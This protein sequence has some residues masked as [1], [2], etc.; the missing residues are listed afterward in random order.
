LPTKNQ[1]L[2]IV[3][4]VEY[5]HIDGIDVVVEVLPKKL[6]LK[7]VV[8]AWLRTAALTAV[9]PSPVALHLI[10]VTGKEGDEAIASQRF[11][12]A[13]SKRE[14][15]QALEEAARFYV[16]NLQAPIPFALGEKTSNFADPKLTDKE[17]KYSQSYDATY[18]KDQ[19]WDL[20]LGHLDAEDVNRDQSEYGFKKV[21]PKMESL[22]NSVIPL[23]TFVHN[24]SNE[25]ASSKKTKTK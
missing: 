18:L 10:Y 23:F 6:K 11:D 21:F 7:H 13:V 16:R 4:D 24:F 25:S 14:A 1:E 5:F 2:Q 22:F 15:L 8:G 3:L 17:W 19:Y 20:A 12:V 9:S